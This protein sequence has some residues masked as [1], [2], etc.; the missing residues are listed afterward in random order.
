MQI[1]IH[2]NGQKFGPYSVEDA[3]GYISSGNL[4][5]AD[6]AWYDGA[7]DWMPLGQVPGIVAGATRPSA[8]AT[9]VAQPPVAP[10][11]AGAARSPAPA[12]WGEGKVRRSA[13][14]DYATV[15]KFKRQLG[16]KN[17][18]Y[19]ALCASAALS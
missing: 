3:N 13:A 19:G 17:M 18:M 15:K 2:R 16:A 1:Y 14:A 4:T 10:V 8:P 6:L 11:G 5:A 12:V 9:S 7:A